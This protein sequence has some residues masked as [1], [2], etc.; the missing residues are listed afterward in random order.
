MFMICLVI[1]PILNVQVIFFFLFGQCEVIHLA[2]TFKTEITC[3]Y[4]FEFCY[5]STS[6]DL[7][8]PLTFRHQ[9]AV[10]LAKNSHKSNIL[11]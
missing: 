4:I 9:L 8:R 10:M 1:R 11:S 3:L 5:I 7:K 2:P 6:M